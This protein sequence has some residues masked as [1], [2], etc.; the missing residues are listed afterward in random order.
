MIILTRDHQQKVIPTGFSWTVLFFGIFVPIFRGDG[1]G[2]LIQF[3]LAVMTCGISLLIIPFTYNR[4]Y[5]DRL[6]GQ[7]WKTLN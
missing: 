4:A 6:R 1:M 2:F 5:E 7:G 3:A